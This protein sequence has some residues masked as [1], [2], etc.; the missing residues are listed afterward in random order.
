[1]SKESVITAIDVGT[2][3]IVSLIA[4]YGGESPSL[5]L[6]GVAAV[7]SE[8]VRKS[9]IVDLEAVLHSIEQ[10]LDAAERMAGFSVNSAF[11]SVSGTHIQSRN[12][13]G[14]VA[15]ADPDKEI[16]HSDVARVIE[17]ARAVSIPAE[18][19][20]IHVVPRY[21]KVDSQS[22]IRDPV[23]M[24]G[25]R[26]ESET[27]IITGLTTPLRNLEKCINDLGVVVDGFVFSGLAASQVSLTETE[28]ELGVVAFDIGA[29]TSSFCCYVDG[30]LEYS[31]SLPIGARHIT[32]DIAMGCRISLESAEKLKLALTTKAKKLKPRSGESKSEFNIRKKK[33]DKI[34]PQE[35][36]IE[37][38]V[39]ELSRST[40]LKGIM[41]PRIEEIITMLGE[42]LDKKELLS[43][44][45]AGLVLTG[46]GA[47]TVGFA[48]VS[49]R[50]LGMP[51]R[52]GS[53]QDMAGLMGEV[54]SPSYAT[55]VGLLLYGKKEGGGQQLRGGVNFGEI[56]KKLPLNNIGGKLIK[57][58]KSLLP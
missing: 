26:L 48:E 21:F 58:L 10:S 47:E 35:I 31:G 28:K 53:P 38:P 27:H 4:T 50:V 37:E 41:M 24:A 8:G 32:Q 52:I 33:A 17:A 1:M 15:V 54:K 49:K 57:L 30:A 51:A 2:D 25:V 19:E 42:K 6:V 18:R 46:G 36:G 13:R 23:G 56:F 3:K 5:R 55:S 39:E 9:V 44:V 12:S 16:T 34:D 22:G 40:I 7:P 29:G 43:E 20:I 45:P 14:V 11:V